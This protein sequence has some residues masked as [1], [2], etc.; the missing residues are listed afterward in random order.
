MRFLTPRYTTDIFHRAEGETISIMV[1]VVDA[2]LYYNLL[3]GRNW[4]YAI[5]II[6]SSFFRTLQF[7]H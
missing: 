5:I 4:F 1:E 7:L 2:P 6:A 3:L